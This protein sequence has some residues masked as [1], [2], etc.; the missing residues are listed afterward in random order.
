VSS[1]SRSRP[2]LAPVWNDDPPPG[3]LERGG[4]EPA[5]A[6]QRLFSGD[7]TGEVLVAFGRLVAPLYSKPGREDVPPRLFALSR[8]DA[9]ITGNFLRSQAAHYD[10][11]SRLAEITAP[12][13]VLAGR[14][15][16]VCS[17][18]D[19]RV[20]AAGIPNAELVEIDAGHFLFSEEPEEFLRAVR[21]YVDRQAAVVSTS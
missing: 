10:L 15:D 21:S 14:A 20:L 13:L 9:D 8:L 18:A 12:T 17:L 3:P 5:A 16:W 1:P 7:L 6:A 19:S 11:R 4:P 2:T